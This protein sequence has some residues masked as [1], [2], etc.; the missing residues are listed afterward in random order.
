M[1]AIRCI[2]PWAS[3]CGGNLEPDYPTTRPLYVLLSKCGDH[4]G[5]SLWT[6]HTS[7]SECDRGLRY[8][9][10]GHGCY[11]DKWARHEIV[12]V[13]PLHLLQ[14]GERHSRRRLQTFRRASDLYRGVR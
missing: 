10:C 3:L 6:D 11:L 4:W 7:A 13:A 8:T 1:T 9:G 2:W 5:L 12:A 14:P